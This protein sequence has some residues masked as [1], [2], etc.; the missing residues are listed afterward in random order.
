MDDETPETMRQWDSLSESHRHPKNLAVVAV[1]SLA[2]P[3]EHRCRVTI[4]Q[5]ADCWNP[6]VSI[7]VET[8]EG[9][10]RTIEIHED[11]DPL[12]LAARVRA[13]AELLITEGA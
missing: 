6:V 10:Q 4:L 2:F 8:F 3:D 13:T 12:S 5:D 7:V 9:G 1:K 11:D